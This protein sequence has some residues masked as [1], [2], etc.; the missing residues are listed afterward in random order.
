[1]VH[2]PAIDD[3]RIRPN[4]R[5]RF[6]CKHLLRSDAHTS[7]GL[8]A[9][10]DLASSAIRSP[11]QG[12]WHERNTGAANDMPKNPCPCV[13]TDV[14]RRRVVDSPARVQWFSIDRFGRGVNHARTRE[15]IATMLGSTPEDMLEPRRLDWI[16]AG[17]IPKL[18]SSR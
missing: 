12:P 15:R 18:L 10:L 13:T 4:P 6:A 9:C 1:M 8:T 2:A 11:D 16:T 3:P 17:I 7:L 14:W 5:L